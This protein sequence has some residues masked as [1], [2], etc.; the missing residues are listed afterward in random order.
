MTYLDALFLGIVQGLTE[1]LPVS[2]TGHLVIAR[3]ILGLQTDY[4]FAV[5]ATFHFATAFAVLFYF[6]KDFKKIILSAWALIRKEHIETETKIPLLA[7]LIGTI[8]GVLFGLAL[9]SKIESVFR[10]PTLVAWALIAGS[11]LFLLAEYAHKKIKKYQTLTVD[12]GFI[13]G[14][15][16]ALALIPGISRSGATISSGMLL[17]LSREASA[18]F[19]FL[20]STPIILG[21][22]AKKLLDLGGTGTVESE[23][24][25]IGFGAFIA[26]GSGLACIHYLLKFLKNHTL[27]LFVMYRI[28]LAVAVLLFLN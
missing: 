8:P 14:L 4:G 7:L 10:T 17:G 1:F 28:V 19:A 3:D 22:G 27:L 26:F 23:W 12:K 9:E 24:F 20:L 21:G 5:D 25:I 13:I 18:R 11:G 15:F 6:R 2:S 16:Q